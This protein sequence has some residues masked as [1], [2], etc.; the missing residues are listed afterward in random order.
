VPVVVCCD[1]DLDY[2]TAVDEEISIV[3][4]DD[5]AF[6]QN[7]DSRL[8]FSG[9]SAANQLDLQRALVNTLKEAIPKLLMHLERRPDDLLSNLPV[10]QVNR[11]LLCC[12]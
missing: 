1:L 11:M 5:Y 3:I 7:L 12:L 2:N 4:A 8:D 10:K 6:A 9:T